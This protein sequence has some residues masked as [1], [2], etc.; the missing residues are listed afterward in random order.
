VSALPASVL[1]YLVYMA[2][3]PCSDIVL[4][5]QDVD[6]AFPFKKQNKM[7]FEFILILIRSWLGPCFRI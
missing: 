6:M 1:D 4:D 5:V 7:F 2:I 3:F